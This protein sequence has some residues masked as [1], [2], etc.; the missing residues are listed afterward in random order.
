[1]TESASADAI[2]NLLQLPK[3]TELTLSLTPEQWLAVA[4]EIRLGRC[5]IKKLRLVLLQSSISEATE[6]VKAVASAIREDRHLESL[7]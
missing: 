6:A 3:D 2:R 7:S 5:L 4:D 1:M